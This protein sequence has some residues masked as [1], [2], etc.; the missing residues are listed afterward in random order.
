ML[1][2]NNLKDSPALVA[3]NPSSATTGGLLLKARGGVVQEEHA[4][5]RVL[6]TRHPVQ[7][8]VHKTI[9]LLPQ[10]GMKKQKV[11]KSGCGQSV[12][13]LHCI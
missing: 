3:L 13:F 4:R 6:L 5:A 9:Y 1:L 12:T 11:K 10:I 8:R 2:K 7:R